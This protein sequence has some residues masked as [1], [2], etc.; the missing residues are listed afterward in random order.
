[1]KFSNLQGGPQR[2]ARSLPSPSAD[3]TGPLHEQACLQADFGQNSYE[4]LTH[5]LFSGL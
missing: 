5:S 1:M 2:N 4:V 3:M